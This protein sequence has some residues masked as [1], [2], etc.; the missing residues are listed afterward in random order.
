MIEEPS[1]SPSTS[2]TESC[3]N[4]IHP[5]LSPLFAVLEEQTTFVAAFCVTH[6][7]A[8]KLLGEVLVV[9]VEDRRSEVAGTSGVLATVL[10]S[11]W[12]G[13]DW[14]HEGCGDAGS[15]RERERCSAAVAHGCGG[16]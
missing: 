7:Q 5:A 13:G 9:R 15:A 4:G 11:G 10:V 3:C 6:A 12:S 16:E 14:N 1:Q 8:L 2:S